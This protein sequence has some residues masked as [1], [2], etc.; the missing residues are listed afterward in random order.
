MSPIFEFSSAADFNVD[1]DLEV[2]VLN[3]KKK[4]PNLFLRVDEWHSI[5]NPEHKL[6]C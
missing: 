1:E 6:L 4:M 2:T 3:E 5:T